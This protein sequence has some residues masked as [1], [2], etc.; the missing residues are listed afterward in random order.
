MILLYRDYFH[1][2]IHISFFKKPN[3]EELGFP[4][5][6]IF[7]SGKN[8]SRSSH[9]PQVCHIQRVKLFATSVSICINMFAR[10]CVHACSCMWVHMCFV[11]ACECKMSSSTAFCFFVL[12]QGISLNPGLSN[13]GYS[14]SSACLRDPLCMPS[15]RGISGTC[16]TELVFLTW[17]LRMQTPVLRCGVCGAISPAVHIHLFS[18]HVVEP[19]LGTM[20]KLCIVD[21]SGRHHHCSGNLMLSLS[22][23]FYLCVKMGALISFHSK[24]CWET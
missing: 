19:E 22:L 8:A 2:S 3:R 1:L 4:I 23:Q 21:V 10:V 16:Y 17:A 6:S 24:G 14:N 9:S 18:V 13:S 12:R 15:E 7:T 20:L 11:C 5:V